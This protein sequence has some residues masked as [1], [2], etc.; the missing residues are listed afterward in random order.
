VVLAESLPLEAWLQLVQQRMTQA[1]A[2]CGKTAGQP[3]HS[4]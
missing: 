1:A 3:Y 2:G 4:S